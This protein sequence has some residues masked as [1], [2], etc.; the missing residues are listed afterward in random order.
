MSAA[1]EAAVLRR[2]SGPQR[3]RRRPMSAPSSESTMAEALVAVASALRGGASL[4][5]AIEDVAAT[6]AGRQ[7]GWAVVR[8]DLLAGGSLR[9]SLQSW[10][11]DGRLAG[12]DLAVAVLTLA[13]QSGGGAAE[14]IDGVATTL[15]DRDAVRAES[16]A[17]AAQAH[18]SVAVLV[19]SPAVFGVLAAGADPRIAG[20][21]ASPG[22]MA[23]VG[24][25]VLLDAAGAWW[26]RRIIGR[27]T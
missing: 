12:A 18:A 6:P 17:L 23:C 15:R 13:A 3:E 19:G 25:A 26:M 9:S 4:R 2:L 16:R 8:R 5:T 10:S 14:A 7:V 24:L 11:H 20:F 22:G 1:T 27:T 21:F